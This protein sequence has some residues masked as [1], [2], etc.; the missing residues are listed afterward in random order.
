MKKYVLYLLSFVILSYTLVYA[1][2]PKDFYEK[3]EI[4]QKSKEYTENQPKLIP[5]IDFKGQIY[6]LDVDKGV[7][8]KRVGESKKV[9]IAKVELSDSS[10][11]MYEAFK[12]RNTLYIVWSCDDFDTQW[13][14]VFAIDERNNCIFEY[15]D[16]GDFSIDSVSTYIDDGHLYINSLIYKPF[17]VKSSPYAIDIGSVYFGE[18]FEYIAKAGYYTEMQTINIEP[19]GIGNNISKNIVLDVDDKDNIYIR[20]YDENKVFFM[21][22]FVEYRYEDQK[23]GKTYSKKE[24]LMYWYY[25]DLKFLTNTFGKIEYPYWETGFDWDIVQYTPEDIKKIYTGADP[26]DKTILSIEEFCKNIRKDLPD[27]KSDE[28]KGFIDRVVYKVKNIFK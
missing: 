5:I 27:N 6:E 12:T 19:Y 11:M 22:D 23:T 3:R 2:V 17:S 1:E 26:S 10:W 24:A 28:K 16:G 14:R 25:Y 7:I 8:Y 9:K 20:S 18:H 4:M 13:V 15:F 21:K